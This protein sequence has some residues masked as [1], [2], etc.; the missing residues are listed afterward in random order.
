MRVTT[1]LTRLAPP[2]LTVAVLLAGCGGS[3]A[4]SG[5]ANGDSNGSGDT[6]GT[7]SQRTSAGSASSDSTSSAS[8]TKVAWPP[9]DTCALIADTL[10]A[11]ALGE[12]LNSAP[13]S[14][15]G[16]YGPSCEYYSDVASPIAVVQAFPVEDMKTYTESLLSR[17][18]VVK[19]PGVGDSALV[20][21]GTPGVADA[22]IYVFAG[23]TAFS[24][25]VAVYGGDGTWTTQRAI[26]AAS[27]IAKVIVD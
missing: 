22:S 14:L 3:S 23:S 10:V 8:T 5:S 20:S 15:D 11:D 1:F 26:D 16:A 7:G 12:A 24:V 18:A 21:V 25:Q 13:E 19:L 6:S 2:A 27:A 17:G 4:G 9:A